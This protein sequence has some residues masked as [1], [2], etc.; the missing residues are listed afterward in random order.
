MFTVCI[1]VINKLNCEMLT[2]SKVF[3]P[4]YL[5]QNSKYSKLY[6]E[7]ISKYSLMYLEF[8]SKYSN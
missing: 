7:F 1:C 8:I 4:V 6:L 2:P 3:Y 5:E